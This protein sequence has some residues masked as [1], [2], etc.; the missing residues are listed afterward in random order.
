MSVSDVLEVAKV[1]KKLRYDYN[2]S[3]KQFKEKPCKKL[4][5][6]KHCTVYEYRENLE[7][8][9]IFRRE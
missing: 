4:N 8:S 3:D 7:C 5:C 9:G 2:V 6:F 1:C